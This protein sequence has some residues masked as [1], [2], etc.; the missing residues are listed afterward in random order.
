MSQN[1]EKFNVS[2]NLE[3]QQE[4]IKENLWKTWRLAREYT[5]KGAEKYGPVVNVFQTGNFFYDDLLKEN[6]FKNI[7]PKDQFVREFRSVMTKKTP[8]QE[9]YFPGAVEAIETMLNYG[10]VRI[11]TTG[12]VHGVPSLSLPG[13]KEQLKRLC[14]GGWQCF[15]KKHTNKTK[16]I[17]RSFDVVADE[18][19]IKQLE[20]VV[21]DFTKSKISLIVIIDDKIDNLLKAKQRIQNL[22]PSFDNIILVW[23]RECEKVESEG[24]SDRLSKLPADFTGTP[25]EAIAHFNLIVI[26]SIKEIVPQVLENVS[27]SEEMKIGWIVD[28]DDVISDDKKRIQLQEEQVIKWLEE[29]KYI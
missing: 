21:L 10:L 1:P 20:Q 26:K 24:E 22:K 8:F 19:K 11:W 16:E 3:N 2:E 5:I 18:D 4:K 25:E 15:R 27:Q 13:S 6:L 12:D 17:P 7:P 28:H 9:A 29:K 23:D 14:R